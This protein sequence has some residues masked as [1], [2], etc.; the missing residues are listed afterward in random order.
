[1]LSSGSTKKTPAGRVRNLNIHRGGERLLFR[2]GLAL[3][4][5]VSLLWPALINQQPFIFPDTTAYVRAADAAA[6]KALGITT[7]WTGELF[8]R[9]ERAAPFGAGSSQDT[10]KQ[11]TNAAPLQSSTVLAGRSIYYGA[12]LYISLFL[13]GSFW[14]SAA[15]QAM[16]T[17]ACI[18]FATRRWCKTEHEGARA[19]FPL[20]VIVGLAVGTPVAFFS[21]YMMPDIFAALGLLACVM[22]VTMTRAMKRHEIVFWFLVLCAA[23]LFHSANLLILA[24]LVGAALVL[25]L[26]RLASV[27]S[28]GLIIVLFGLLVGVAGEVAFNAA[29]TRTTGAS[30]IRPPFIMARLIDDGAGTRYLQSVCPAHPDA[31]IVCRYRSRLP[32]PSDEFLWNADPRFG[33]FMTVPVLEQ[34]EL[35]NEQR[36]F[37]IGVLLH[38]PLGQAAASLRAVLKQMS[39]I[40]LSEFNYPP[41]MRAFFVAKL[42]PVPLNQQRTTLAYA[43]HM[44]VSWIEI[45]TIAFTLISLIMIATQF[46]VTWKRAG[47][48][49]DRSTALMLILFGVGINAVICGALSTPHD[50]YQARVI[51]LLP[52]F[53]LLA[54]PAMLSSPVKGETR[55]ASDDS[56][57]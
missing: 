46:V 9:Q 12:F 11:K 42:P 37:A 21:C 51:W 7:P 48:V 26:V 35:S 53:A 27:S 28:Q 39:Y 31:Y 23:A 4:A 6:F 43:Q 17:A 47:G 55:H 30:P 44:P 3:L 49:S 29:V 33:V 32:L 18:M 16:M 5:T 57:I 56:D 1:M 45:A 10:S 38:D 8:K 13:T 14:L 15:T 36:R 40:A 22:L 25:R 20:L 19:W 50:R 54:F 2:I 34:R 41:T 52:L 24:A